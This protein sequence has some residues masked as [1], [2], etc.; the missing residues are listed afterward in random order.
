MLLVQKCQFFL[1]L[2]LVKTR[3]ELILNA[4]VKGTFCDYNNK[5]YLKSPKSLFPKGLTHALV[6]KCQ[7]FCL[8]RFS[9]NWT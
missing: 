6:I 7:F 4:F 2:L 1:Y 3:L 9:E 5:N 8:C